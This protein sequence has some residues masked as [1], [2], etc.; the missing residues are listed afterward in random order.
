MGT[1]RVGHAGRSALVARIAARSTARLGAAALA[2]AALLVATAALAPGAHAAAPTIRGLVPDAMNSGSTVL[3]LTVEG[4]HLEQVTAVRFEP[5]DLRVIGFQPV[6]GGAGERLLLSVLTNPTSLGRFDLIVESPEGA[7]VREDA[8]RLDPGGF[9]L[10]ATDTRRPPL[11]PLRRTLLALCM[12]LVP[13]LAGGALGALAR[14]LGAPRI[15]APLLAAGALG[16][17]IGA[18]LALPYWSTW[19]LVS[20][21]AFAALGVGLGVARRGTRWRVFAS[22]ALTLAL[23][24]IGARIVLPPIPQIVSPAL[25]IRLR[26]ERGM[27]QPRCQVLFPQLDDGWE[28]RFG[29]F[30]RG[31][32]AHVF[33]VGDSMVEGATVEEGDQPFVAWLDAWDPATRHV[34]VGT[35]STS[36]DYLWMATRQLLAWAPPRAVVLYLYQNDIYELGTGYACCGGQPLVR[37]DGATPTAQCTAPAL[38]TSL[39]GLVTTGPPPYAL[40][41]L[42]QYSEAARHTLYHLTRA[43]Q[44]LAVSPQLASPADW[45][46]Q[47]GELTA[48]LRD[49]VAQVRAA[50]AEPYVV[51]LP[52]RYDLE[53]ALRNGADPVPDRAERLLAA[54]RAAG[55]EPLDPTAYL[56][57]VLRDPPPDMWTGQLQG[58]IDEHYGPGGHRLMAAW[59]AERLGVPAP[60]SPASSPAGGPQPQAE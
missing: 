60:A 50:G 29:T 18:A 8:F 44:A 34:N 10:V 42:S 40:R 41:W 11:S 21:G 4:E 13:I 3:E 49:T 28:A 46:R 6:A 16:A 1:P 59:L 14:R 12:V 56:L 47:W 32:R 7:V 58:Q 33:H 39:A 15:V 51:V 9:D 26:L 48:L 2:F 31:A 43:A 20:F 54:A 35:S 17:G 24:E 22:A 5:D 53:N 38:D 23:V 25:D 37:V 30:D 52:R 36:A 45:E 27:Q 57:E 19:D 55:V